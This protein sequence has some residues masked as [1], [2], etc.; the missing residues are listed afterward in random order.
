MRGDFTKVPA[1]A[2]QQSIVNEIIKQ[3][4]GAFSKTVRF[5]FSLAGSRS[6]QYSES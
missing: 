1:S 6:H 5:G 3:F 2:A 4:C